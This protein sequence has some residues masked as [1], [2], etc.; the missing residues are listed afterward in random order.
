MLTST[1]YIYNSTLPSLFMK[2]ILSILSFFFLTSKVFSQTLIHIAADTLVGTNNV[3]TTNEMA[4]RIKQSAVE[5]EKYA[6]V[7]RLAQLDFAFAADKKEFTKLSGYGVL[8]IPSLNQDK[9]EYPIKKVYIKSNGTT[10]EL[11]KIGELNVGVKDKVIASV[12]GNNRIDY[13][14]LLPYQLTQKEGELL[15]DWSSNRTEFILTKFPNGNKVEYK[16]NDVIDGK[17]IDV[18]ALNNFLKREFNIELKTSSKSTTITR[19]TTSF[20]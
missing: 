10:T 15:I 3:A 17:A 1:I 2:K 8:Y 20:N 19:L 11:R 4:Q 7:P 13:Y 18:K 16:T 9:S 12:F 5:Y 14:Y 6:P